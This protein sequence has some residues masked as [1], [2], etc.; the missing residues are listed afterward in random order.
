MRSLQ[1]SRLSVGGVF[2]LLTFLAGMAGSPAANAIVPPP[3]GGLGP[4][5]V[6]TDPV[7]P[8]DATTGTLPGEA[9][10]S[11]GAA[12]YTVPIE[13]PPG[14]AGMQPSLALT[15]NSRSGNGVMGMGWTISGMSSIHRCPQTPEQDDTTLASYRPAV[16]YSGNDRLCL[17]GRRLVTSGTY[18]ANGTVYHTEI[19]NYAQITQVGGTGLADNTAC[20]RVRQKD[21]RVLHYGGVVSADG[22]KCTITAANSS[23]VLPNGTTPLS[24][25]VE[26][27]EDHVGNNQLYVY[28]DFGNGEVLLNTVTYT[29]FTNSQGVTT[30]GDRTVTFN[31]KARTAAASAATDVASSYLAGGLTMQTQALQSITTAVGGADGAH[32]H[33]DV[34]RR[35]I[36]RTAA[37]DGPA[38]M[39]F[40]RNDVPPQD[41]FRTERWS[42]EFS[43][44]VA[45]RSGDPAGHRHQSTQPL[46][47]R[48]PRWRWRARGGG[49]GAG[50]P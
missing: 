35:E 19:D 42:A 27:I 39:R 45:E 33:A 49:N 25:L 9:G 5:Q 21:G 48:R 36:Q 47:Y 37:D 44:H 41:P 3:G 31:Y 17:D 34:C 13:V 24:W 11:G 38:G 20:F 23:R 22:S 26:K 40:G 46:D 50:N 14:R 15:Y 12:T 18:G 2:L 4:P 1:G 43:A 16:T 10:T 28:K 29:G 30:V 7:A 32:L 8:H 6:G